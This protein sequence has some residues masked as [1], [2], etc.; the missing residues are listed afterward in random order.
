VQLRSSGSSR[1]RS[2]DGRAFRETAATGPVEDAAWW[3][4]SRL[5]HD[6]APGEI[7]RHRGVARHQLVRAFATATGTSTSRH[8]R[9]WAGSGAA[10]SAR[11]REAAAALLALVEARP[12]RPAREPA[13]ALDLACWKRRVRGLAVAGPTGSRA[14]GPRPSPSGRRIR[15]H[16]GRPHGPV[17]ADPD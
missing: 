7:A 4:E 3:I 17:A 6:L 16:R 5:H 12:G 8:D 13:A 10:P 9:T 11:D 14:A 2:S 15:A 1:S